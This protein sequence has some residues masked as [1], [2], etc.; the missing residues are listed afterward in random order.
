[1]TKILKYI[2]FISTLNLFIACGEYSSTQYQTSTSS[3]SQ[4]KLYIDTTSLKSKKEL[5]DSYGLGGTYF[6]IDPNKK[7]KEWF[8]QA[9]AFEEF[10]INKTK[11]YLTS[12]TFE[13]KYNYDKGNFITIEGCTIS[14]EPFINALK[15][16]TQV[17]EF[18]TNN[19]ITTGLGIVCDGFVDNTLSFTIVASVLN[20]NN[21][22]I[23]SSFNAYEIPLIISQNSELGYMI[24]NN[25]S[26]TNKNNFPNHAVDGY[27]TEVLS[28]RELGSLYG[29]GNTNYGIDPN[30]KTYEWFEQADAFANYINDKSVNEINSSTFL[31]K[32]N[33]EDENAHNYTTIEG[34][35]I[36]QNSFVNALNNSTKIKSKQLNTNSETYKLVFGSS[37]NMDYLNS[38]VSLSLVS[39]I[40]DSNDHIATINFDTIEAQVTIK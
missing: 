23:K 2:L 34:C 35:T 8:E 33:Y 10:A 17:L 19:N 21:N 5:G 38:C 6:G 27:T 28:K 7:T 40:L 11:E 16:T 3:I 31:N 4:Q 32:Y 30:K 26:Q 12:T 29:L 13:N 18:T 37:V 20:E 1:M 14:Q 36:S 22:I 25:T 15:N 9:N 39:Y 24:N